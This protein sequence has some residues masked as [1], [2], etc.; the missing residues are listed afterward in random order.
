MTIETNSG[1]VATEPKP[2]SAGFSTDPRS[3]YRVGVSTWSY[4]DQGIGVIGRNGAGPF[5]IEGGPG[6]GILGMSSA[7]GVLG[8]SS[9][10]IEGGT[11]VAAYG[12]KPPV[13]AWIRGDEPEGLGS[14]FGVR[15]LSGHGTG[16]EGQGSIGVSG[17]GPVGVSGDGAVG[18]KG[19]GGIGVQGVS[20]TGNPGVIGTSL[21][22]DL[23]G[24]PANINTAT[25]GGD[26]VAGGSGSGSGVNG[27]SQSGRGGSFGGGAAAIALLPSSDVGHPAEGAK[28]DLVVDRDGSLYFCKGGSTWIKLA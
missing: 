16:V 3:N 27:R 1:F 19:I 15:G 6:L 25:G 9:D 13:Q 10:G 17:R 14:G 24:D 20:Y 4:G 28:G 11:A 7:G 18:V 2:T 21:D 26:G 8:V 12:S 22:S 5:A 23:G